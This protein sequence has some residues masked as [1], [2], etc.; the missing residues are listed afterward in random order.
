MWEPRQAQP[1]FH[2]LLPVPC[3][4]GILTCRGC[5]GAAA[6]AGQGPGAGPRSLCGPRTRRSSCCGALLATC[7]WGVCTGLGEQTAGQDRRGSAARSP[8]QA[9]PFSAA[10][11]RT[12]L[13]R[14]WAGQEPPQDHPGVPRCGGRAD[15]R[16]GCSGRYKA[17]QTPASQPS[18]SLSLRS[19]LY[20]RLCLSP[21]EQKAAEAQLFHFHGNSSQC[22]REM[23]SQTKGLWVLLL[24]R[25][26]TGWLGSGSRASRTESSA[27][28]GTC[29]LRFQVSGLLRAGGLGGWQH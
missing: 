20:R 25:D 1:R 12:G 29:H 21:C 13:S 15:R 7:T 3:E 10:A 14:G 24:C 19:I 8:L 18:E 27:A 2:S 16:H 9:P 22:C 17:R 11:H 4:D 26:L 23:V 5:C 28:R 6:S